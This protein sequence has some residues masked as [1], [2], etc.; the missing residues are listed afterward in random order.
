MILRQISIGPLTIHIY[1]LVIAIAIFLGW[2]L[3][4][5]RAAIYKVPHKLF[6]DPILIIPLILAIA[7]ARVY[8]VVDYWDYYSN[9]LIRIFA[10][11]NGGLGILG[12]LAGMVLGF[13]I[14]ARVKKV[15]FLSILDLAAPSILLGQAVGRFANFINQEGFG[16][17]TGKPWG[18]FIDQAHRPAEYINSAR[19]HPTFFYEAAIN[20]ITFIILIYLSNLS[21]PR[22]SFDPEL[23][24]EG[25]ESRTGSRIKEL[26]FNKLKSKFGMTRKK[27]GQ[28]FALYLIFYSSARFITEFWRIDTWMIG[29]VKVAHLL[30]ILIFIIGLGLFMRSNKG[31]IPI[32][33]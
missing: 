19:F 33:G 14:I 16:P 12:A 6:D 13:W 9:N 25:R 10:I 32:R 4:K 1:G 8:H 29:E 23:K 31:P 3:A 7:T 30:S 20:F 21:F 5:K 24:T 27:P 2:F 17:P 18:I 26:I 22:K 15:N 28:T 11:G